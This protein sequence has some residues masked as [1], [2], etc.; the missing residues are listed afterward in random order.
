MTSSGSRASVRTSQ[1]M[2]SFKFLRNILVDYFLNSHHLSVGECIDI[3]M[4]N[5]ILISFKQWLL[6]LTRLGLLPTCCR[7]LV[8][9]TH[10]LQKN[11]VKIKHWKSISSTYN[12]TM[13]FLG[14]L[15]C[16]R[17]LKIRKYNP[18]YSRFATF[19][20]R[21]GGGH[22]EFIRSHNFFTLIHGYFRN[23]TLHHPCNLRSS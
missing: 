4:R 10:I 23:F 21:M 15:W 5:Y 8:D 20:G 2:H 12:Q 11:S 6:T 19:E 22:L 14:L 1:T 16:Y 9:K 13:F 18:R 3:S 17:K 7:Q